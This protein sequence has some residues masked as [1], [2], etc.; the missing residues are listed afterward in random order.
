MNTQVLLP[1]ALAFI[2]FSMGLTLVAED[3]K[4][5]VRHPRAMGYG[6]LS[7]ILLLPLIGFALA[8]LLELP[9]ELAV[10]LM[11][12]ASSPGGITSNL[13]TSLANGDTALSVS[14]TAV[15]SLA[16]LLTLPL[17]VN[18]ALGY[19]GA[20]SAPVSFPLGKMVAGIFVISTLPLLA[21]MAL[22]HLRPD[23]T[24]RIQKNTR[25]IAVVLF[26]MI[27]LITFMGEWGRM[28]QHLMEAGPS[29]VLLNLSAMGLAIIGSRMIGLDRRQGIAITI[30]CGLQNAA[31]GIFLASP[32][33]LSP[34]TPPISSPLA[35]AGADRPQS[36]CVWVSTRA[37]GSSRI[38]DSGVCW[39]DWVI[40]MRRLWT[41][42]SNCSRDFLSMCGPR[43][44]VYTERFVG[45][46]MGPEVMAP[47]LRAVSTISRADRSRIR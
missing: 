14:L 43:R 3:F 16:S 36:G 35:S 18:F 7:Q 34:Q 15:T 41:L 5:V 33:L 23:W 19:W 2:M 39:L 6:L 4:R 38:R 42:I 11:I 40:S 8:S 30:E 25:R 22:R 12:L 31:M 24:R 9:A 10:G 21:G 46:G 26:V 32:P 17:L 1:L 13:L 29:V 28:A 37:G 20:G 45:K 44:T 47:V 27:V